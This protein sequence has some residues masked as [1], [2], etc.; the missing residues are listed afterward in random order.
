MAYR[1]ISEKDV[2]SEQG[3]APSGQPDWV[4]GMC[5]IEA[6]HSDDPSLT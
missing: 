5:L 1:I 6:L 3:L 2:G 4:F